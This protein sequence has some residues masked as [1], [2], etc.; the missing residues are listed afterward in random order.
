MHLVQALATANIPGNTL[1]HSSTAGH[2]K[3]YGATTCEQASQNQAFTLQQE[4]T[5]PK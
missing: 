4:L 2:E 5:G 3:N 1:V